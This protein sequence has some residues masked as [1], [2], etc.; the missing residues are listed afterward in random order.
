VLQR[1]P[2]FV[3]CCYA[4][5]KAGFLLP[6]LAGS[7]KGWDGITYKDVDYFQP[8][9]SE[10]MALAR[11]TGDEKKENRETGYAGFKN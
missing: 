11:F 4:A 8:L 6:Y 3:E 9:I 10:L 1:N 7:V 2:V 5:H